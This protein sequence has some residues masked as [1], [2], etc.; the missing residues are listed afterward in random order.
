MDKFRIYGVEIEGFY[1]SLDKKLILKVDTLNLETLNSQEN[2]QKPSIQTQIHY[3]KTLHTLLQYFQHIHFKQIKLKGYQANLLYDG[4]NFTINFPNIY[5]KLSLVEK[6]SMIFLNLQDLYLHRLGIYT[7]GQGVYSLKNQN[8]DFKGVLNFLDLQNHNLLS[9]INLKASGDFEELEISGSSLPFKD[10]K[11]LEKILPPFSN[12][13][14]KEWIFDNYEAENINLEYFSFILPTNSEEILP[15]LSK[16]LKAKAVLRNAK[17]HFQKNIS[18]LISK[19]ITLIFKDNTLEF[20]PA[21]PTY[22][23]ISLQDS[24]VAI[25]DILSNHA[26]LEINLYANTPLTSSIHK[27]LESYQI[28]LPLTQLK[29]N[30]QATLYLGVDLHS[31]E[32]TYKGIFSTQDASFDYKGVV[33]SGKDFLVKLENPLID[34]KIQQLS[35]K[36]ILKANTNFSINTKTHQLSGDL[37]IVNLEIKEG[38]LSIQN[39][40]L[41]FIV[42]FNNPSFTYL[43][44]PTF[45][46]EANLT[47]TDTSTF[48]FKDLKPLIAYSEFLQNYN[49]EEGN[50]DISTKDFSN[51][52]MRLNL[53]SS[54]PFMY[55]KDKPSNE[56]SLE[57]EYSKDILKFK[58]KDNLAQYSSTQDKKEILLQDYVLDIDKLNLSKNTDKLPTYLKAQNSIFIYKELPILADILEA[59]AYDDFLEITLQHKN[60]KAKIIKNKKDLEINANN[61]GDEFANS[62][63]KK[64]AFSKGIFSL[65]AKNNQDGIL[66]GELKF[67]N[68]SIKQLKV[69]QNLLAFID[70]IPSLLSLKSPGFNNEGYLVK[71]GTMDFGLNEDYLAINNLNIKGSSMDLEGKGVLDLKNKVIDL[72]TK[73]ITIKSLSNIINKIPVVNYIFLGKDGTISTGVKISGNLDNPKITTQTAQD[74]LLSP[75]NVLKRVITSPIQIFTKD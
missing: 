46:I 67:Y 4:E 18:P 31:L 12:T 60:G 2:N 55:Q 21:S 16:T 35:F 24:K 44:F 50:I 68:T 62:L 39:H 26:I 17:V 8:L 10:I 20:H 59:K 64:Q 40:L 41:P 15:S 33:I 49:I 57:L 3:A 34:V 37:D 66:I 51:F 42:D 30:T 11:F 58:T 29:S 28:F 65:K 19:E 38:I 22:E 61:F 25:K 36:D 14:L 54:A 6:D 70:T 52:L 71:E 75:F 56:L 5:A 69:L 32:V 63:A 1:L 47:H 45:N 23:G 13:I 74:I 73:L 7:Q 72:N 53:I 48:Y 27:V 9:S 43:N